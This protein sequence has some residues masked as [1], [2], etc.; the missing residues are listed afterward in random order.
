M[1]AELGSVRRLSARY[2]AMSL[3][4]LSPRPGR[5]RLRRVAL[6][7]LVAGALVFW[8]RIPSAYSGGGISFAMR[9]AGSPM[10]LSFA[11][12][13][14]LDRPLAGVTLQS[15]SCSGTTKKVVTD[16]AGVAYIRPG[17]QEVLAVFIQ[18]REFRLRSRGVPELF[19]PTCTEGLSFQVIIQAGRDA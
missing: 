8:L 15:E 16:S 2:H 12:R 10:T 19:A 6:G 9:R 3:H 11:V 18:G 5:S 1:V 14:A 13:D 7:L 17:E 4:A